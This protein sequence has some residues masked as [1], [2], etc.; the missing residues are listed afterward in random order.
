MI[1]GRSSWDP[2]LGAWQ[3]SDDDAGAQRQRR[4]HGVELCL[5]G[6]DPLERRPEDDRLRDARRGGVAPEAN[7]VSYVEASLDVPTRQEAERSELEDARRALTGKRI[8]D[9]HGLRE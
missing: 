8:R 5:R 9:Q 1:R 6:A 2:E 4:L 7:D 3:V